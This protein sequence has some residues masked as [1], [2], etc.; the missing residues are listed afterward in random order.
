M[1]KTIKVYSTPTC[2]YCTMAKNYFKEQNITFEDYDVSKDQAKAREM[3]DLS[4][5]MG[6]PVISIDGTVI[7]GF[8][9]PKIESA[10]GS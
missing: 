7:V 3:V 5:Q 10:L 9:K 2:P 4:G 6:V 8:D 1:A